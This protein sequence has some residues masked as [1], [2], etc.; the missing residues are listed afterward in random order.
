MIWTEREALELCKELTRP[1]I[2]LS[3]TEQVVPVFKE[4][5]NYF[6]EQSSL[7]KLF[8][9]YEAKEELYG[10]EELLEMVCTENDIPYDNTFIAIEERKEWGKLDDFNSD[11]FNP[12]ITSEIKRMKGDINKGFTKQDWEPFKKKIMAK[13]DNAKTHQ[14]AVDVYN[15]VFI[16][17]SS[18]YLKTKLLLDLLG[19]SA[20]IGGSGAILG[21][22]MSKGLS[23]GA[24]LLGIAGAGA[25]AAGV[26][27][28][29]KF[30]PHELK[31][32]KKEVFVVA[33]KAKV[34]D[35]KVK[36]KEEKQKAK[37]KRKAEKD[38]KK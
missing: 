34:K 19:Y 12:Y 32:W 16:V 15:I 1:N 27:N 26:A 31:E 29:Y 24:Q 3:Y 4:E 23:L 35:L 7:D 13:L 9:A 25:G 36:K 33:Y 22:S 5:E 17:M 2:I 6:V 20:Y 21:A 30:L 28:L 8:I 38:K 10:I 11:M 37:E 18:K 14:D